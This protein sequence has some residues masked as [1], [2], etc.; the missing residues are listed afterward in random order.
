MKILKEDDVDL[1]LI[2]ARDRLR[3]IDDEA[4]KA[5]S[6]SMH[7]SGQLQPIELRQMPDGTYKLIAGAHRFEAAQKLKWPTIRAIIVECNDDEAKLREIDE[8]LYRY[9]LTP[10]DQANFLAERR[11]IWERLHGKLKAGRPDGRKKSR[12]IGAIEKRDA[13]RAFYEE[14]TELFALPRRTVQRA[15]ERKRCIIPEIWLALEG[16]NESKKGSLLDK[17]KELEEQKQRAIWQLAIKENISLEKAL[18]ASAED[19]EPNQ[20]LQM[21]KKFVVA[22]RNENA[23]GHKSARAA[24]VRWTKSQGDEQ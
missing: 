11:E 23:S 21:L 16:K 18:K 14:V 22:W 17:I 20:E 5:L 4:V 15:L 3:E 10:Y 7:E 8:N 6:V 12:Q 1:T 9:E 2:D 24:V 13:H 19:R